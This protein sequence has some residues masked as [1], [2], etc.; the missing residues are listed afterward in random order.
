MAR[1]WGDALGLATAAFYAAYLLSI[2]RLRSRF[3]T[4]VVMAYSGSATCAALL[5]LALAAGERMIPAAPRGWVVLIAMGVVS[6]VGGQGLIT[7]ALAHLKAGFSSV[8]LLLQ[9]VLATILAWVL[10]HET[11]TALQAA[12]GALVLAGIMVARRQ[13]N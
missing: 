12:G 1:F 4:A 8:G 3:S 7:Y 6:H 11:L 13:G 9:P 5:V 10:F 2:K